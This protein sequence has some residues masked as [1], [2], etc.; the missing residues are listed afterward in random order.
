MTCT[1]PASAG[2][3]TVPSYAL[4]SLPNG[5][6]TN[7]YFHIAPATSVSFSASDLDAG[8]AQTFIDESVLSGFAMTN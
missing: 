3:F 1:A 6:G 4:F 5:N 8:I 7:F 2:S